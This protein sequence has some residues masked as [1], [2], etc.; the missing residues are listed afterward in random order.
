MSQQIYRVTKILSRL[1]AGHVCTMD[2]LLDYVHREDP[3]AKVVTRRQLERD[4][5]AIMNS[6]VAI[7]V[8][9]RNKRVYYSLSRS[10][11]LPTLNVT[12][13]NEPFLMYL[14]KASL[15]SLKDSP[16]QDIIATLRDEIESVA[17]GEVVLPDT[18]LASISLGHYSGAVDQTILS[19]IISAVAEKQWIRVLY[20]ERTTSQTLFPFKII[21]YLG[22]MYVAVWHPKH[23]NYGVYAIDRIRMVLN[24]PMPHPPVPKF[25]LADFMSTR[26]GLW[27]APERTSTL[28]EVHMTNPKLA[29]I[30]MH[31][32]WHP[33]QR[34]RKRHDGTLTITMEAGVSPELVSW[35]LHWAPDIRVIQPASLLEEVQ[36]RATQLLDL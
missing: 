23:A 14:L 29:D 27:E 22:R 4:M 16:L 32:Y 26:F 15:P 6:G 13:A 9:R 1:S 21:P 35:V 34:V 18:M 17:P 25:N 20:G 19:D 2:D 28:I 12:T 24:A 8:E 3:D 7:D 33:T 36:R 11:A 30:F 31:S 5:K 10:A